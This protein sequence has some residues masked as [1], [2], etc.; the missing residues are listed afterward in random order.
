M[1]QSAPAPVPA[2]SEAHP[3][4]REDSETPVVEDSDSEQPPNRILP[5]KLKVS[6]ENPS[7]EEAPDSQSAEL[8]QVQ[9]AET[10][11]AGP[12]EGGPT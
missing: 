1:G 5:D 9:G 2:S 3:E 6:W 7:P 4:S 8:P 11:E 12:R 10:S